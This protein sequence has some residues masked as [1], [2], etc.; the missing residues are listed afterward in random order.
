MSLK[1]LNKGQIEKMIK[2]NLKLVRNKI[3]NDSIL[4]TVQLLE[5]KFKSD[6]V[7][8]LKRFKN[9]FVR[10]IFQTIILSFLVLI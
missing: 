2:I 7:F 6:I 5:N 8:E 4:K 1:I 10:F 9:D 3:I